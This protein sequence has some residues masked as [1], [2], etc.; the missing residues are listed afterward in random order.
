MI[1]VFDDSFPFACSIK[2]FF[3]NISYFYLFGNLII[4]MISVF[5]DSFPFARSIFK[6]FFEPPFKSEMFLA[7]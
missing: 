1:F 6:E 4:S 7:G 2:F 5:G 3:P